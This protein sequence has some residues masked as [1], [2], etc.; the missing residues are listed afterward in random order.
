VDELVSV[1]VGYR[2]E[3]RNVNIINRVSQVNGKQGTIWDFIATRLHSVGANSDLENILT[4]EPSSCI[5]MYS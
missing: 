1:D 5:A 2:I 3:L 4:G